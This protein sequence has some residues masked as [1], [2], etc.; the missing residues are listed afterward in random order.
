MT[1]AGRATIW[2]AG[3]AAAALVLSAC[4][5]A[6]DPGPS[7]TSTAPAPSVTEASAEPA[8]APTLVPAGTAGQNLP[9]FTAIVDQVYATGVG[10]NGR[11]FIDALV[12][13]GF[14]KAAMQVTP[15]LT[16]IGDPVETL[17]FSVRWSDGCLLGQVGPAIG[18]PVTS[19]GPVLD[20][21][22]CLIGTTRTI[23]W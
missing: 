4:T 2:A 3:L 13:G 5:P 23:D 18:E 9:Y 22:A 12:A 15:D 19:V 16:T 21:G 1:R 10:A 11:A 7:E 8:P 6:Q 14:D 20:D 17:Q